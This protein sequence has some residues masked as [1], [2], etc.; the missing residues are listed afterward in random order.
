MSI[1]FKPDIP[2]NACYRIEYYVNLRHMKLNERAKIM[3]TGKYAA[4]GR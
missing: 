3:E 1:P 4:T 2:A